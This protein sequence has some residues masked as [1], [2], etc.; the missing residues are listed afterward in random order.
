MSQDGQTVICIAGMHRSG[1]S[2]V[3][4]LL[5]LCGMNL[6]PENEMMPASPANPEGYWE[7]IWFNYYNN[8]ILARFNGSW[9][10]V[11]SFPPGWHNEKELDWAK[12]EVRN[13]IASFDSSPIWG[14]KDPRNSITLPFW[15][16]LFPAMGT[17]V[18]LRNPLDVA[19]SLNKR[20]S[21][22]VLFGLLL[23]WQYN[24]RLL[25]D[26]TPEQRVVTHFDTYFQ[27]GDA[28]L[29]R[30]TSQLGM[31]PSDP[32]IAEAC[33][34]SKESLRH[35]ATIL[36]DLQNA[37]PWPGLIQTYCKL[38]IEAGEVCRDL[39]PEWDRVTAL[40][41]AWTAEA[42]LAQ[43]ANYVETL[44][45]SER[46]KTRELE[47]HLVRERGVAAELQQRCAALEERFTQLQSQLVASEQQR[48]A[49]EQQRD[50]IIQAFRVANEQ[51]ETI[52]ASRSWKLL[53]G[54][55]IVKM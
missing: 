45:H 39:T 13:R 31:R 21:T 16:E 33:M 5:N 49:V 1:T 34:T 36:D 24:S 17:V 53:K 43:T 23:W 22:S 2:M 29:R 35:S 30:L 40:A 11:P 20:G 26:T 3:T 14:W 19:K 55:G 4:R 51:L 6:G 18:C 8:H 28:E 52:K 10:I 47:E 9:D 41:S 54:I 37:C 46:R 48:A 42:S 12:A 50:E 7:H 44:Y 32:A 27:K 25:L 38:L 15:R